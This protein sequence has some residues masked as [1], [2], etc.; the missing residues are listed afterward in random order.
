MKKLGI[1]LTA[2]FSVLMISCSETADFSGKWVM[3]SIEGEAVTTTENIPFLEFDMTKN[4]VHGETGVN[5]ING[6]FTLDKGK[7]TFSQMA[8]TMM[9][10]PQ[11]AMDMERKF[12]NAL[13]S[14]SSFK[15]SKKGELF[16]K[17]ADG[18]ELMKFIR[19]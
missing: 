16:L 18:N 5:I 9:A 8:T 11:E 3:T 7:L 12:L 10:G 19:K 6:S 17:D 2:V 13:N 14:V 15:M 1:I 4:R